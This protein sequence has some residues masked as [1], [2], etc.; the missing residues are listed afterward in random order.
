MNIFILDENP[1]AAA[2]QQCDKHIV[3]MVTESAQML[4]TAHRLLDGEMYIEKSKSNRNVKRW[5]LPDERESVLMKA[6]HMSHPCTLWTM[7]SVGNYLWHYG[8]Y[9]ALAEE[10]EYRYG[11]KHGAFSRD[12][13]IGKMLRSTPKNI[14]VGPTTPYALAMQNEPQCIVKDDPV[15]SYRNYYQT[16]QNRFR[17]VWTKR[18]IPEWFAV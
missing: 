5:R 7:A 12:T 16:K 2:E 10:Y 1:I 6:V 3:K 14:K 8:H 9:C 13:N 11:K 15:Q 4:S 18:D 17:M